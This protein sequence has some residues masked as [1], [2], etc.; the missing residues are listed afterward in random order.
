MS[1]FDPT[2]LSAEDARNGAAQAA[3]EQALRWEV[4]D[5]IWL[6]GIKRGRRIVWRQLS[7]A[8]VYQSSFNTDTSVMAF[9]EGQRNVGLRLLAQLMEHCSS[10]YALM[11]QERNNV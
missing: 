8:G 9:N 4:E 2:D 6:M 3:T 10:D 11:V 7:H 1:D 5:L